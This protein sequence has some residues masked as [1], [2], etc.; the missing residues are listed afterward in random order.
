MITDSVGE[1]QGPY[2]PVQVTERFLQLIWL[3]RRYSGELLKTDGGAPIR[4][5]DPGEWNHLEGPDFRRGRWEVDGREVTGDVEI[6]FYPEDWYRHG[7]ERDPAFD[8]VALHVTLFPPEPGGRPVRTAAGAELPGL[9]LL[10]FLEADLE[11]L[12]EEEG[13][14][15]L[16]SRDE[17][18][19]ERRLLEEN[20]ETQLEQL[21]KGARRRWLRKVTVAARRL[22]HL[23]W[24]GALHASTLEVLGYSRNRAPMLKVARHFPFHTIA[25]GGVSL[26]TLFQSGQPEW[27]TG[28]VRPANHPRRRL[29]QYCR[30]VTGR[31]EW[32]NTVL[33]WTEGFRNPVSAAEE[34]D[35]FC[36]SRFRKQQRLGAMRGT[37]EKELLRG[38][39]GG[40]RLSAWITDALLP[41]WAARAGLD[42]F[43]LWHHWY[44]GDYPDALM[45][46]YRRL[47][48]SGGQPPVQCTGWLQGLL[49]MV[50]EGDAG[51]VQLEFTD[52]PEGFSGDGM[53]R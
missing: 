41:L 51:Y 22:D 14:L 49:A 15:Q 3:H 40:S 8:S 25:S 42:C 11:S 39:I 24:E 16:E 36:T 37:L 50:I 32:A 21:R 1:I 4:I 27:S 13:L 30:V 19:W 26:E 34:T 9:S 33:L 12:A 29:E 2:G 31:P 46:V 28:G 18:D 44:T 43:P 6:H 17:A 48:G 23:G 35:L 7:H 52:L 53:E 47:G 45:Q 20:L 38:Q 10:S 5:I